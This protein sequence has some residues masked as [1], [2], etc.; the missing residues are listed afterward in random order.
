[1]SKEIATTDEILAEEELS[2]ELIDKK[3]SKTKA[4]RK[5]I[6]LRAIERQVKEQI[7][8]I[9]DEALRE[10]RELFSGNRKVVGR[11]VKIQV[12]YGPTTWKFSKDVEK[13]KKELK[14]LQKKEKADGIA[15]P[16]PS[17]K[18]LLKVEIINPTQ[19][20]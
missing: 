16:I 7:E 17:D 10:F 20:D 19:E 18:E 1:M 2:P 6:N 3:I 9:H 14:E 8:E 12:A 15:K 11:K 4:L 13:L 5:L